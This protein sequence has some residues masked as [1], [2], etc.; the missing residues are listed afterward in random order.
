M[1]SA[2]T[3]LEFNTK[4]E[5]IRF[6]SEISFRV[7]NSKLYFLYSDGFIDSKLQCL[8]MV[9]GIENQINFGNFFLD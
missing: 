6:G 1:Q 8:N 4:V 5:Q 9:S 2:G 3:G 7:S